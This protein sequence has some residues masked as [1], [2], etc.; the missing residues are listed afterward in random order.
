MV[1]TK[2]G[3]FMKKLV[4]LFLT[5]M[6][7]LGIS[8]CQNDSAAKIKKGEET[9]TAYLEAIQAGEFDKASEYVQGDLD[10][11]GYNELKG[12]VDSLLSS[13]GIGED[14][15]TSAYDFV[16]ECMKKCIQEYEIKNS[17]IEDDVVTVQFDGKYLN[18]ENVDLTQIDT[19]VTEHAEAYTNEH[20]DELVQLYQEQ[21]Q[22]AVNQKVVKDLAEYLFTEME[23][24]Y[25]GVEPSDFTMTFEVEETEDGWKIVN[26]Q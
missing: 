16:D 4:S 6:L 3:I 21:G 19:M 26:A 23:T 12:Y 1:L 14:F 7:V 20:M 15:G 25:L 9:A 5:F 11:I 18:Y 17:T 8:G 22:D 24:I 13:L 2:R 10:P